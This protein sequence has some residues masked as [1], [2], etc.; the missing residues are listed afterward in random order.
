MWFGTKDG[1]NRYDGYDFKIYRHKPFDSTSISGN[2][3]SCIFEDSK[4]RLWIGTNT[5]NLFIPE[6]ETFRRIDL[7]DGLKKRIK[8]N[9]V[10][11]IVEDKNGLIWAGTDNGLVSHNPINGE[12]KIYYRE[13]YSDSLSD[14]FI[15]S[16]S[17]YD[18]LLI[19]GATNSLELFKLDSFSAENNESKRIIP[20]PS[21]ES[22]VCKGSVLCQFRISP[23][24]IY[25][26]T[27]KGL[28]K[29]DL[30]S[31][32]SEFIPYKGHEF[33]PDWLDRI[34]SICQDKKGNLWLACLGGLVIYDPIEN[35]FTYYFHNPRD[36]KSLS[37]N[38]I[39]SL[40]ADRGN[41][42]W[43]GTGG[44]GINIYDQEKKKFS[45]YDGLIDREP[46]KSSFSV[47]AV[48]SDS[49]NILWISS[50]QKLFRLNR[51]TGTYSRV[52]LFNNFVGEITSIVQD[53]DK[54]IWVSTGNGIDKF[55]E[56]GKL[57]AHYNHNP[58]DSS[59]L[60]DNFVKLLFIDREGRLFALNSN[61]LS[62]FNEKS[63]SFSNYKLPFIKDAN[64]TSNIRAIYES[65]NGI[66]WF[67][68]SEGLV[69]YN[70]ET[71]DKKIFTHEPG[72]DKSIGG[73]EVET[74]C[75]DPIQPEK[76]LWIGTKGGGLSRLN[77]ADDTFINYSVN[78]GLPND[79]IYGILSYGN[80]LW[81]ST[82]YGLCRVEVDK[83]GARSFRNYE[84]S[85]GL[86]GNEFNT[87]AYSKSSTGE[88]FFGGLNGVNA[89]FP[90][91]IK[92]NTH[93]PPIV[94]TGLSFLN[95]TNTGEDEYTLSRDFI[96]DNSIITIPYFDN[97]VEVQFAALDY[98]NPRKNT[99]MYK[100]YPVHKNWIDLGTQRNIMF[101]DLGAGEYKL[102]VKG[103][104]ND[105]IWN[106]K[107]ASIT[108]KILSP[109][110][111]TW[112]AYTL[113]F[114]IGLSL[115]YFIRRYE[116]NRQQW[117]HNLELETVEAF[118]YKELNR[119]KSHFF[120]N[121]SHEFRTPISLISGPIDKILSKAKD[122]ETRKQA[123]MIK[124]NANH[125]LGLINQLLDLSKLEAGKL[126]LRSSKR[127]IVSFIKG[128]TM[129]FE[130]VAEEK[131]IMLKVEAE[132]DEIE[133]YFDNEKMTKIIT[134]LLSNA[135]KFT[136]E[137]GKITVTIDEPD[138]NSVEIKVRDTG[139]G[140]AEKELPK[141]F[142][143]FYQVDSS[144]KREHEGMG[145]GLA[146]TKEL[147]ELHR[148][149]I[150]A[151]SKAGKWTEFRINLPKGR[152]HL[153]D[154]EIV[155]EE[156]VKPE[157]E[158]DKE[159]YIT[160]IVEGKDGVEVVGGDKN[161]VLV[162]EDNADVREFIKDSLGNDFQVEEAS[163]G[164]QGIRKAEQ[165]IPDMIISDIMMP[166]MNGNELTKRLKTDEKTSH[167]PIILL[168]AKSDQES[169]L[170]GLETGADDYL[171]KPFDTNELRV[172]VKN[173][174]QIRRKLQEKYSKGDYVPVKRKESN[175][176][177]SDFEERFMNKVTDV[178]ENNLSDEK[179]NI[180]K[181]GEEVGMSRI[182]LHRKLKALT[183]KSASNYLRTV[184]LSKARRL[185]EEGKGNISE[186]AYSVGFSSP[187]Y[188][189]RCFKE[190][191]GYPPSDLVS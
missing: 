180:E 104:N 167:I 135:L 64:F 31:K 102:I 3:I 86:Q 76:Y 181:F 170:E 17:S 71:H 14:N 80:E 175:N 125:L 156:T 136:G 54:N 73:N 184:R 107:G 153:G 34:V 25:A 151:D 90:S 5:L 186:I 70:P 144:Q 47:S 81:L 44:K 82:N 101:M 149:T 16:L 160:I 13:D 182:Q 24:V 179:F 23:D 154:S 130:S 63:N 159:D 35:S 78:N 100:L 168:T 116:L 124:R 60:R 189:T 106:E 174:I 158:I 53:K 129:S 62:K 115:L 79:V 84:V 191:Y 65:R 37:I 126:S 139:I 89:F 105:G 108:I 119:M 61:Y 118:K 66:L 51:S 42:I 120:A 111:A 110:W 150:T 4:S 29:I 147:I 6:D 178:I 26:G 11:A 88:L 27:Q 39:T 99:Y 98:T 87:G 74:I 19:V 169:R 91:E 123:G 46:F 188:F 161:V 93:M 15:Y 96:P 95:K 69:E 67:G 32:T 165:I 185:I 94:F 30:S 103:S 21:Y 162:V 48:L 190:E 113:Y 1:L 183:G 40:Y 127:N 97:S 7:N 163:N 45:L 138:D 121:I 28:V 166:K 155:K 56:S 33:T 117:K 68:W 114:L 152:K 109:Y 141:I 85:D 22:I 172:R 134:N 72:N 9:R 18:S 12:S 58:S 92:D 177:L 145:I 8:F 187:Q 38:N 142:D 41:K 52:S 50:Q 112:W 164:E 140:I 43:I 171:I 157:L 20:F 146:L 143:R 176:K 77:L 173:L 122:D 2:Y 83:H 57:I 133:L 148:G 49:K 137:G 132:K 55:S 10:T 75:E 36:V 128:M 131:D 59:S